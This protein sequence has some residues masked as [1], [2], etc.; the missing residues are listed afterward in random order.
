MNEGQINIEE[1]VLLKQMKKLQKER[2]A[3]KKEVQELK[4]ELTALNVK[5][6]LLLSKQ[7]TPPGPPMFR[8]VLPPP[9]R[10]GEQPR[11][12]N[13]VSRMPTEQPRYDKPVGRK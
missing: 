4:K 13:P 10:L 5:V 7:S 6:D 9:Y 8:E 12:D 11:Y 1:S 2:K 3:L